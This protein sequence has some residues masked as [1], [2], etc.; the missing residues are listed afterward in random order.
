MRD[1]SRMHVAGPQRVLILVMSVVYS[2]SSRVALR[3]ASGIPKQAISTRLP[4]YLEE[5]RCR[6]TDVAMEAAIGECPVKGKF[7][8]RTITFDRSDIYRLTRRRPPCYP[9]ETRLRGGRGEFPRT[10]AERG[11][12]QPWGRSVPYM[13]GEKVRQTE[14]IRR[15][16]R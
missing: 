12:R 6:G 1:V 13:C 8:I 3:A 4:P 9:P 14:H 2:V 15:F 16:V 11:N 5:H 7:G 10:N